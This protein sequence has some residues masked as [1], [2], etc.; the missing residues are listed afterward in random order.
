MDYSDYVKSKQAQKEPKGPNK[1]LE[2]DLVMHIHPRYLKLQLG[3]TRVRETRPKTH[4]THTTH[5]LCLFLHFSTIV[6]NKTLDSIDPILFMHDLYHSSIGIKSLR[7][8]LIQLFLFSHPSR[9]Q[10]SP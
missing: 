3:E 8:V 9:H 6:D 10:S 7:E 4:T 1:A 2:P 5:G